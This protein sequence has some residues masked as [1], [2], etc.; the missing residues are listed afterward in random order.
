MTSRPNRRG[1][2]GAG[3]EAGLMMVPAD[4][5]GKLK[6]GLDRI[7]TERQPMELTPT[8]AEPFKRVLPDLRVLAVVSGIDVAG[9]SGLDDAG[10][11]RTAQQR[12]DV[13]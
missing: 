12:R 13:R 8:L 9:R 7:G 11:V 1:R 3:G 10:P 2:G 4:A 5:R 6:G